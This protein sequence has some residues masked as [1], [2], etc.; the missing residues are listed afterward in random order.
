MGDR[1][2]LRSVVTA[3]APSSCSASFLHPLH[4]PAQ[5]IR[6]AEIVS[7]KQWA[8]VLRQYIMYVHY[9]WGLRRFLKCM[10]LCV[11]GA[12]IPLVWGLL[13]GTVTWVCCACGRGRIPGGNV[14]VLTDY[15][16]RAIA[17]ARLPTTEYTNL[18]ISI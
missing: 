3:S 6:W 13:V 9:G 1:M 7:E 10:T 4:T 11:V 2:V 17:K 5:V 15:V 12:A 8:R 14:T 16:H 18:F